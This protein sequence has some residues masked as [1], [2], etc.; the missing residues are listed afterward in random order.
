VCDAS[1]HAECLHAA[2]RPA[3]GSAVD[4]IG[5]PEVGEVSVTTLV[6]NVFDALPTVRAL[7]ELTAAR[8]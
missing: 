3:P 8:P 2:P 1:D 7:T 6:D 5:L 4:P